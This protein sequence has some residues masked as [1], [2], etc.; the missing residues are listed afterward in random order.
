[1]STRARN[2]LAVTYMAL[3]V[4][5]AAG[6]FFLISKLLVRH[7]LLWH[8]SHG[9]I[10]Y[11]DFCNEYMAGQLAAA[12]ADIYD[13]QVQFQWW[14]RFLS[15]YHIDQ[16][17]FLQ[18]PPYFFCLMV[19]FG[20]LP[21]ETAYMV[22]TVLTVG[23]AWI[24]LALLLHSR[25]SFTRR[26]IFVFIAA[27]TASLPGFE[28]LRHG[29]LSWWFL[30]MFCLYWQALIKDKPFMLAAILAF[31]SVK[32]Q[33]IPFLLIPLFAGRRWRA[34]AAYGAA[35]AA[36]I[37]LAGLVVGWDNVWGWPAVLF[38][39]ETTGEVVGVNP[40]YMVNI[41]ALLSRFLDQG[42]ALSISFAA[43]GIGLI[44]LYICWRV[45]FNRPGQLAAWA[46]SA[47]VV[48]SI[49]DSPHC[50]LFDCLL[51]ALPAALTAPALSLF[52]A[53]K[54]KPATLRLWLCA[55]ILYPLFGVVVFTLREIIPGLK[56]ESAPVIAYNF[57]LAI[58]CAGCFLA[59]ARAGAGNSADIKE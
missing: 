46:M 56:Y 36:I 38:H 49:L 26:Q 28:A 10:F 16:T 25:G 40:A 44:L 1:M 48:L 14:N 4:L 57:I 35:Q 43:T 17:I 55:L 59:F 7:E 32:P 3:L 20:L 27:T 5:W 45:A 12:G 37:A 23:F 31:I 22:Y 51:L 13:R 33:F 9:S 15:P 42:L 24:C 30:G 53:L 19:P 58:A 47:T 6:Y 50:H 39:A 11:V 18:S 29:Q 52:A 2:L 21:A 54:V 34:L 41:R 8:L